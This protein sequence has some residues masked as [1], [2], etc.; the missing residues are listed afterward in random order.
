MDVM[1]L[2]LKA[3][4][5]SITVRTRFMRVHYTVLYTVL[6]LLVKLEAIICFFMS[7]CQMVVFRLA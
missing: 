3:L 6:L 5:K 2:S 1:I 7:L 4:L